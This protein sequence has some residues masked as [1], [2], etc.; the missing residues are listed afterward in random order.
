MNI[1][2]ANMGLVEDKGLS[3]LTAKFVFS[4]SCDFPLYENTKERKTKYETF[5][6]I[7]LFRSTKFGYC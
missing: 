4:I 1:E 2:K 6:K 7:V 3:G 5:R